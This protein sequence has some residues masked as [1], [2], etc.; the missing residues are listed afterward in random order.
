MLVVLAVALALGSTTRTSAT[1]T[2]L[3]SSGWWDGEDQDPPRF[4]WKIDESF[5]ESLT[6]TVWLIV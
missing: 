2:A 4:E 5:L 3:Y 6:A 1:D